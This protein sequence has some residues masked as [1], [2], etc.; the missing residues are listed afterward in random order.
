MKDFRQLQLEELVNE[1]AEVQFITVEIRESHGN[2]NRLKELWLPFQMLCKE[3][4]K[5]HAGTYSFYDPSYANMIHFLQ[6]I[7]LRS[8][9][10]PS[11]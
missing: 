5:E 4:S 3:I 6:L 10:N 1:N 9:N 8:V 2:P 11:V 7:D